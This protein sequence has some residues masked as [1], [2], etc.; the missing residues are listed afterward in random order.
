MQLYLIVIK[1]EMKT[2]VQ[3]NLICEYDCVQELGE[4]EYLLE[5]GP[6]S[7]DQKRKT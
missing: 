1:K 5:S 6:L 2:Q 4:N 7:L 3:D